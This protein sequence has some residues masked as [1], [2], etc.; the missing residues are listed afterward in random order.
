MGNKI[1]IDSATMMNK[2][3]EVIEAFW[4]FRLPGKQ[5]EVVI[6]PQSI[7]HSMVQF[8]DGS[9]KAQLSSPDMKLPILYAITFPERYK[10]SGVSTDFKMI[11]KLTFFEPDFNKFRCLKMAYE[12]I[13]AGGTAP[14]ILN[15]ANEIAVEKFLTGRIK[16]TRIPVLIETALNKI[17]SC[18]AEDLASII[19]CDSMTREFLSNKY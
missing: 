6:H 2:G 19:E 8:K 15:A 18:N 5:I 10:Y 16:F 4:L 13:E 11:N 7:I 14:C 12:V 9:I 17:S 1:T 3:L